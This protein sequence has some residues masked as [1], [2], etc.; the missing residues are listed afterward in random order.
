[1]RRYSISVH[2][3]LIAIAACF[4]ACLAVV[5]TAANAAVVQDGTTEAGVSLVPNA[6]TSPALTLPSGI[7]TDQSGA[8]CM[9][10][11]LSS[12]LKGPLLPPNSLCYR[13]G[14][15]MHK[16]ETFA[17]TW[18]APFPD[19]TQ[20]HYWAQT[21]QYVEQFL[22][23]VADDSGSLSSPFSI[24][25]QYGSAPNTSPFNSAGGPA[26]NTSVF[27]GGCIDYGVSGSSACEYGSPAGA[28]H[29]FPANGCGTPQGDSFVAMGSVFGNEVCLT[30]AQ[31]QSEISTMVTQTGIL[32]RTQP[33]YTPLV[34]LLLPPGVETCL[35]TAHKLCSANSSLFPPPPVVTSAPV[36]NPSSPGLPAG[37]YQVE[38]T[39]ELSAGGQSAP[40]ASQTVTTTGANSSIT[41]DAPPPAP[42]ANG[43]YVYVT[44]DDGTVYMRQGGGQSLTSDV[45]LTGVTGGVAPPTDSAFCSYHS[46]VEVGGTEIPYVVQPWTAG[47]SCDEPD[48]PAIQA[49]PPVQVLETDI[50]TRLVSPLSQSEI[51]AI[52]NPNLNGW[53]A[54]DGSEIDDNGVDAAGYGGQYRC[55]PLGHQLDQVTIGSSSQNPYF[56][57]REFNNAGALET[58]PFTYDGCAPVDTLSPAFVA[59]S[60]VDPGDVIQFDGSN[61]AST[62]IVPNQGYAWNFGDGTTATGPSVVHSY[63]NPGTY[64]VTLTT[65]D[66]GGNTATLTQ[67]VQV[68][69]STGQATLPPAGTTTTTSA[70]SGSGSSSGSGSGA[71]SSLL[72]VRLQLL[73]QSLKSVLRS[74]IAV[75]VTSNKAA[76][77][78]ATV[79][80]TRAAAE[81]AHIKVGRARTVRIGLGTVASVQNGSVTLRLHLSRAMAKK[82]AHLGHVDMTIRLALVAAGNQRSAI[83]AAGRY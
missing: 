42:G 8:A 31:L 24:T 15:V 74:G 81:R 14:A 1:M 56:L 25:T 77:G 76:N 75:R 26:L 16:N 54:Q 51:A 7:T 10:P 49:N 79:S 62:L 4:V 73:P 47:T 70:T 23:D 5:T 71:G 35:D 52:V 46:Q 57:Q 39:Y 36:A 59:P 20:R 29:D 13:G 33:G 64:N 67:T 63:A 3:L 11:W 6:R 80:I 37:N 78:I 44:S 60:A 21:K 55:V 19:Q 40:S 32:G 68:L 83:D 82:L 30:D 69:G 18:D 72:N 38:I 12:D 53:I 58:D 65:T 41:I 45:Q 28:G 22:R 17:L 34:T 61:T 50:G 48:V 66:R 43:W 27:G 2:R 9:D